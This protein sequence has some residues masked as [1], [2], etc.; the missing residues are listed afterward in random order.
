MKISN[1]EKGSR[2]E[3]LPFFIIATVGH[4]LTDLQLPLYLHQ[5]RVLVTTGREAT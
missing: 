1:K 2:Q 3:S 5:S 4:S